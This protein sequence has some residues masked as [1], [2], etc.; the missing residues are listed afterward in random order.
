MSSTREGSALSDTLYPDRV[1]IGADQDV[2]EDG[3]GVTAFHNPRDMSES[4]EKSIPVNN[5]A[6]TTPLGR[7]FDFEDVY[8]LHT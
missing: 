3:D 1:V 8:I 2:R 5:E 7:C 4:T 6:H